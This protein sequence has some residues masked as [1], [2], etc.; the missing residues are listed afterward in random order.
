M[1]QDGETGWPFKRLDVDTN[2]F[3][4][5]LIYNLAFFFFAL[6]FFDKIRKLRNDK[7]K[8]VTDSGSNP[9]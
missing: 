7:G 4:F 8:D 2:G 1:S 9:I 5:A 3:I 6:Y